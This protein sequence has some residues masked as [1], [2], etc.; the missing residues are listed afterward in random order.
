M[1]KKKNINIFNARKYIRDFSKEL[2]EKWNVPARAIYKD[3]LKAKKINHISLNEYEW[4]NYYFLTDEQKETVSTLKTR[5]DF[6]AHFTNK[7]YKC[8]LMNK[9]IFSKVF[10]EFFGRQCIR[11]CDATAEKLKE[12]GAKSG[13]VIAK[14]NAKGQGKGIKVFPVTTDEEVA[15]ALE[16]ILGYDD[17][18][19][20]EEYLI[21]HPDIAKLNPGAV[22]IIRFYS[23]CTPVA[24]YLFA[25][26]FTA[27]VSKDIANGCQD[28]L[29]AMI[30]INTGEVITDAVDQ[31][32]FVDVAL[33]PVTGVPFKGLKIPYWQETIEMMKR[34][35]PLAK[36][37]S[38]I[39]W[40]VA[41]T[42]DGP[43]IIEANTIPGFNTAQYK[44]YAWITDGYSYRPIFDEAMIGRPFTDIDRYKRVL[45]KLS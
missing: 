11:C 8:I 19:V 1:E 40:D 30:D 6:R 13:K 17:G 36:Q 27:A 42:E 33:H 4:M 44:G 31:N 25:P 37:I 21:Q 22:S 39:G 29:T 10:D 38:N 15:I 14:P 24:S 32:N 41:I 5:A 7:H 3:I 18:G 9:Y 26:V 20:V 16:A 34:A 23:V 2:G 12:M 43:V 28:A 45:I 35:V